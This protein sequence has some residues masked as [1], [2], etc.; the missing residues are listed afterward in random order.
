MRRTDTR[1]PAL[2]ADL[3]RYLDS[4][5]ILARPVGRARR[6]LKW[7]RRRPAAA[8]L[9]AVSVLA[10]L[11]VLVGGWWHAA[12]LRNALTVTERLR[13]EAETQRAEADV[14][15]QAALKQ[16]A[17]AEFRERRL[18]QYL[19]V[20]DIRLALAAWKSHDIKEAVNLL[21]RHFQSPEGDDPRTF[22]W[23]YL[24][25]LCHS[26]ILT[27]RG[28]T[29]RI[30]GVAWSPDGKT[31]ATASTDGTAKLWDAAT[32]RELATLK[33][34]ARGDV[35]VVAFSPDGQTLATGGDDHTVRIWDAHTHALRATCA[36]NTGDVLAIAFA[37]DGKTLAS[38][39]VN[40]P[41]K[42]WDTN[43]HE[44]MSL[45][46][47][48]DWIRGL[49]FSSDGN[50]LASVA[51]D[52]VG[53]VWDLRTG[54]LQSRFRGHL[55]L[56]QKPPSH[57]ED[58][59]CVTFSHDGR[60][61]AS[62]DGRRR[63]KIW[64]P[65]TG[66]EKATFA[67][68][69]EAVRSVAFS[70]DDRTL[71]ASAHDGSVWIWDVAARKV[72]NIIRGH[73][74]RLW[75]AALSP[76]GLRL[77]TASSDRTAKIWDVETQ[78]ERKTIE[79]PSPVL[80]VAFSSDGKQL[81]NTGFDASALTPA[82]RWRSFNF[83]VWDV[84]RGVE[85]TKF[86]RDGNGTGAI[87]APNARSVLITQPVQ[88]GAKAACVN[89]LAPT[90]GDLRISSSRTSTALGPFPPRGRPWRSFRA[91]ESASGIRSG[92]NAVHRC[93]AHSP[94]PSRR[95]SSAPMVIS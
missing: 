52:G 28:H 26:E 43:G 50:R 34:H 22:V 88:P 2:A 74:D 62:G 15:R 51:T 54:K 33:G 44:R 59:F 25:R 31:L 77:A 3:K 1:Q 55:V 8:V 92:A 70:A 30:Y 58:L 60:S 72:R 80:R 9:L 45:T 81:V 79:V 47:H 86:R 67:G 83:R 20:V 12:T 73:T 90:S 21:S 14:Q 91:T 42:L 63:V 5:P 41:V 32:G 46:G 29:G 69:S 85:V 53:R 65:D 71:I 75:F 16:T 49:A 27:L 87:L 61:V 39:G 48:K 35:N 89:T 64:D 11:A 95:P 24:W 4:K 38:G 84:E 10:V 23:S 7:A 76:D 78:Q 94:R 17:I 19:Y 82:A 13:G 36:G 18:R 68:H 57:G 40:Q 66:T 37:P 6:A 56:P 93:H